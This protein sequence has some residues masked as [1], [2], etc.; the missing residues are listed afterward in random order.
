MGVDA[1]EHD[2]RFLGELGHS[3][4]HKGANLAARVFLSCRVWVCAGATQQR[5][6]LASPV[7]FLLPPILCPACRVRSWILPAL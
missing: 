1:T 7:P 4:R 3:A 5:V 2:S 6:V